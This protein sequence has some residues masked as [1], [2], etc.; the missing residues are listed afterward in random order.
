MDI[1][2]PIIC[3]SILYEDTQ[4]SKPLQFILFFKKFIYFFSWRLIYCKVM[5]KFF[6]LTINWVKGHEENS[7]SSG[8]VFY[9]DQGDGLYLCLYTWASLVAQVGK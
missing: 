4:A 2:Y 1:F 8:H 7:V 5:Y 6:K 9:L 3:L